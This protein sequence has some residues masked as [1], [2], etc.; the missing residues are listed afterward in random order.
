[1]GELFLRKQARRFRHRHDAAFDR[2]KIPDLISATMRD[3]MVREF[4]CERR[5]SEPPPAEGSA[6][7]LNRQGDG[8]AVLAGNRIVG[9]L[10]ASE[11]V[12]LCGAIDVGCGVLRARVVSCSSV[13]P[14]FV[15]QLEGEP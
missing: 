1:M 13:A 6:V 8:I 11:V 12:S 10:D 4:R 15:V 2:M 7:V 14:S 5:D 3:V 9:L